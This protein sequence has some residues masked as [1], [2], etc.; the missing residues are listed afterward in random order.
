MAV[1]PAGHFD[2]SAAL[3]AGAAVAPTKEYRIFFL[4]R[5]GAGG[6]GVRGESEEAD[7]VRRAS[8]AKVVILSEEESAPD[9]DDRESGP[10]LAGRCTC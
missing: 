6:W 10:P 5:E 9:S 1:W 2:D 3:A 8:S 7:T 4:A